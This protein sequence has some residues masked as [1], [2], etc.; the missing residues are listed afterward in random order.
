MPIVTDIQRFCVNDGPGIRT[1]VFLK[2]CPLTCPWCHNPESLS[3]RPQ[4]AFTAAS[5][6]RCGAC[7]AA[8]PNGVHELV[9]GRHVVR[10]DRCVA[11]G[12]CVSAC[13]ANALR[14]YG[15]E[16]SVEQIVSE[17]AKD[18]DFYETSGGG[19]T[20]SGGECMSSYADT[21]AIARAVRAAGLGLCIETSGLGS[22]E[23]Y[24]ELA[25]LVDAFL[26]DYK[27][28]GPGRYEEVVG[29]PEGVVLGTLDTLGAV[30]ARVILRCPLVPGFNDTDEHF[31]HIAELSRRPGVDHV[32]VLPYHDLGVGKARSIGSDRYVEGEPMPDDAT[33]DAWMG[34]IRDFGARA[35]CRG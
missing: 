12:A 15:R 25:G 24:R 17:V 2:G 19:V 21:L 6:A 1:T 7:V 26:L 27:V 32:E 8:C 30:G 23:R 18:R 16:M 31:S 5:C 35:V 29:L 14:I 13:P 20:V 33:V 3:Y 34:R 28:S 4:L 10:F 9:G 22:P 11:C